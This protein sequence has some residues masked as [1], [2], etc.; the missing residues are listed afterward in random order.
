MS[1]ARMYLIF[2][3]NVILISEEFV[4]ETEGLIF[5]NTIMGG[6]PVVGPPA[7]CHELEAN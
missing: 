2:D 7:K 3:L 4:I 1:S 6:L 5:T